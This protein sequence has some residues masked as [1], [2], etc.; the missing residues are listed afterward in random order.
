VSA[1]TIPLRSLVQGFEEVFVA[2]FD[3]KLGS[4]STFN[5]G[6]GKVHSQLIARIIVLVQ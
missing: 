6:F 3:I 5:G 2:L 1:T 4:G